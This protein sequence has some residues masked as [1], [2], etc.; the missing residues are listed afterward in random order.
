MYIIK[1][2]DFQHVYDAGEVTGD[3]RFACLTFSTSS[4]MRGKPLNVFTRSDVSSQAVA[5]W[6]TVSLPNVIL[7]ID[8]KDEN[9]KIWSFA[10]DDMY[11]YSAGP[12]DWY[13]E[14]ETK[15]DGSRSDDWR[16]SCI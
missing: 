13:P 1:S 6:Q 4:P 11:R 15:P 3:K 12:L 5:F 9:N 7:L 2:H 10:W 16:V 14:L 8:L